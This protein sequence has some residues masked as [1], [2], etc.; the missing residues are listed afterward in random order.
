MN[1]I[2]VVLIDDEREF[3]EPLKERLNMR[4]LKAMMATTDYEGLGLVKNV[5]PDV[6]ILDLLM[7][8]LGGIEILRRL[9]KE[10]KD[11][12]VIVTTGK[13]CNVSEDEWKSLGAFDCIDK[14]IDIDELINKIHEAVSNKRTNIQQ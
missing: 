14:P 8:G 6:V 3:I 10:E 7:P 4:G 12:Q 9:K 13:G 2:K 11:I 1:K 5:N